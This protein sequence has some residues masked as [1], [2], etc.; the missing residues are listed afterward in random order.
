MLEKNI[1]VKTFKKTSK[2]KVVWKTFK[3][4]LAQC[5]EKD[6]SACWSESSDSIW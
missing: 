4:V 2:N 1:L 3:M 5:E 6:P